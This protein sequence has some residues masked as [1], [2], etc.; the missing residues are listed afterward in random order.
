MLPSRIY[1]TPVLS[2]SI[3][4]SGMKLPRGEWRL[5]FHTVLALAYGRCY[6]WYLRKYLMSFT[7]LATES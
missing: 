5:G 4:R 2:R 1:M 6:L 3:M 7:V